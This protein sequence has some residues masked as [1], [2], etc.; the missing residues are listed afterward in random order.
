MLQ[1]RL[2]G[3]KSPSFSPPCSMLFWTNSQRLRVWCYCKQHW[4]R[5]VGRSVIRE[6]NQRGRQ[7]SGLDWQNN[8]FARAS[9]FFVPFFA[10][11]VQLRRETSLFHVLRRCYTG[12]F[13]T[14]IFSATQC[15]IVGTMS[16]QC[17]N[18]LLC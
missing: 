17:C 13:E 12:R 18:A 11:T 6:L 14:T 5:E 9:R 16:Q 1:S 15:C 10:V 8:N 2:N 7:N 4:K 3:T